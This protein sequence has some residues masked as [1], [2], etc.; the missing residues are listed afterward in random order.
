M[1]VSLICCTPVYVVSRAYPFQVG[2]IKG[3]EHANGLALDLWE[4]VYPNVLLLAL[5]D[6]FSTEAFYKV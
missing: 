3:Y 2:A 4:S 6:T 1:A 5:T